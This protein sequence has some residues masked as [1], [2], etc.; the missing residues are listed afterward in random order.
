MKKL[1]WTRPIDGDWIFGWIMAGI[2]GLVF[3]FLLFL[4]IDLIIHGPNS[5]VLGGLMQ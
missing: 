2:L 4:L 3:L 5:C 1:N